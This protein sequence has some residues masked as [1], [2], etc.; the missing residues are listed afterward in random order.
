M[1]FIFSEI[2]T[3]K[4]V[5]WRNEFKIGIEEV[6]FEHQELIELIN[7]SYN[8]AKNE[9]STMAVICTRRKRHESAEI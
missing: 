6:D 4:L 1:D 9:D 8:K 3:M 7:D 2:N 5:E